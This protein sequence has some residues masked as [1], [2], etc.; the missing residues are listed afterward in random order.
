MKK[1][2]LSFAVL[3]LF[4]SSSVAQDNSAGRLIW[5]GDAHVFGDFGANNFSTTGTVRAASGVNAFGGLII[6]SSLV[7]GPSETAINII[8]PASG[9][10]LAYDSANNQFIVTTYQAIIDGASLS[11]SS[12]ASLDD[13]DD[14]SAS[15]SM[16]FPY[17]LLSVGAD[18]SIWYVT[19]TIYAN[20]SSLAKV[21]DVSMTSTP[22]HGTVL[23]Y[24]VD[25]GKVDF[26]DN[27]S[28]EIDSA[29]IGDSTSYLYGDGSNIT[30]VAAADS[31]G[32]TIDAK[33]G[34]AAGLSVGDI[35]YITEDLGSNIVVELADKDSI[36]AERYLGMAA[37]AKTFGQTVNVRISG[38]LSGIDVSA[39]TDG[40]PIWLGDDGG[41]LFSRPSTGGAVLVGVVKNA[42]INGEVLLYRSEQHYIGVASAEDYEIRLGDDVGAAS[43]TEFKITDTSDN[44]IF[45]VTNNASAEVVING[46]SFD[47]DNLS[48]TRPIFKFSAAGIM[49]A[50]EESAG[51]ASALADLT[52]VNISGPALNEVLT[53][54]GADWINQAISSA[55]GGG[56]Q[57]TYD[58]TVGATD[59][60]HSASADFICDGT[61]DELTIQAAIDSLDGG[62]T[63]FLMSGSYKC[64]GSVNIATDSVSLIGAG[65]STVLQRAWDGVYSGVIYVLGN[66]NYVEVAHLRINGN[67]TTYTTNTNSC[68]KFGTDD[69]RYN[70]FHDL[71]LYDSAG[72]GFLWAGTDY[73]YVTQ[74]YNIIAL[75]CK[76]NGFNVDTSA[77][78]IRLQYDNCVA[79][80]C[81]GTGFYG[82]DHNSAQF[83]NCK[84]MFNTG[85]GFQVGESS[86]LE[87]CYAAGNGGVGYYLQGDFNLVTG[88]FSNGNTGEGLYSYAA[89]YAVVTN[90][91][92]YNNGQDG[93]QAYISDYGQ[94]S[95]NMIINNGAAG[96]QFNGIRYHKIDNNYIRN[97]AGNG[98]NLEQ[99]CNC[100]RVI[101][102][103]LNYNTKGIFVGNINSCNDNI[104]SGNLFIDEDTYAIDLHYT[105]RTI[106]T[107]NIFYDDT[108]VNG[109]MTA[110]FGT[111]AH[112]DIYA[113]NNQVLG[114]AGRFSNTDF[115]GPNYTRNNWMSTTATGSAVSEVMIGSSSASAKIGFATDD[116][117]TIT[118][119]ITVSSG[120][121]TDP[122]AN[123]W[124]TWSDPALK[125]NIEVVDA[126]EQRQ[127]DSFVNDMNIIK[128]DWRYPYPAPTLESFTKNKDIKEPSAEYE[129]ALLEYKQKKV[130]WNS[131]RNRYKSWAVDLSTIPDDV[132]AYDE[133]GNK[134]GYNINQ[135]V[136]RMLASIK[137]LKAQNVNLQDRLKVLEASR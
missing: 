53:Y 137:E 118:N 97:N 59:S 88:C 130:T 15:D 131:I 13:I 72:Y 51:G 107:N 129:K 29:V 132:A 37:E 60:I 55:G 4:I 79:Y 49:E 46:V 41:M 76:S 122:I 95:N 36:L 2:L 85:N 23:T 71:L 83:S 98:I 61:N 120:A 57:Y 86:I 11:I 47:V 82:V 17:N 80:V 56:G 90:N 93:I 103:V 14:V 81:G 58:V 6:S 28:A 43:D 124:A 48:P 35:V 84:A 123:N 39:A 114:S 110:V 45:Q 133:Q 128:F 92:F 30:N 101:N 27:I 12:I 7:L 96:I 26:K 19:D 69:C 78:N 102:N 63:V 44:N 117:N 70:K 34:E 105:D 50:S 33:V 126:E 16:T 38:E 25:A 73:A 134:R 32:L 100:N 68:I 104:I 64:E 75:F 115:A 109:T 66:R 99:G 91:Y 20:L 125:E 87:N 89:D 54:D 5:P 77:N 24:D 40:D 113:A 9:T 31:S 121:T 112:T 136:I 21:L 8:S 52:D 62:G 10:V 67:S 3:V 22:A 42:A 74:L 127:V 1:V 108:S 106:V 65:F 94:Y 18:G 116:P 111:G 135:L 119:V